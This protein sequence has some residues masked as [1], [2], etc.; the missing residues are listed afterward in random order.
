MQNVFTKIL[1]QNIFVEGKGDIEHL[2][3]L[4]LDLVQNFNGK[5]FFLE[6]LTVDVGSGLQPGRSN[7]IV[8]DG[9][10]FLPAIPEA[11]QGDGHGMVDDLEIPA[12]REFFVKTFCI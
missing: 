11:F 6:G 3:Q 7:A 10:R 1:A 4:G 5:S 8:D 12:A 9:P 2:G